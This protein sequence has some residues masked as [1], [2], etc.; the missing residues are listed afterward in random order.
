MVLRKKERQLQTIGNMIL[1]HLNAN[2]PSFVELC[3]GA[4]NSWHQKPMTIFSSYELVFIKEPP[5]L[6]RMVFLLLEQ[7][8]QM[9]T[10]Y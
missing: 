6:L 5:E 2:W 9:Y 10:E 1:K 4:M 3:L 8:I 7:V